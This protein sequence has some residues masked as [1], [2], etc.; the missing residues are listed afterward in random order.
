MVAFKLAELYPDLVHA[1]VISGSIL[2][3]TDSIS[4]TN[5]QRLG[6]SSSSEL[7]LPSSVKGLKTLLRVACHKKLWFPDCLYK[8]YLEVIFTNRKERSEL[9]EALVISNKDVSVPTFPQ[10]IHL[11]WGENDQIF[12]LELAQTMKEQLV[13][14]ATIQGIKKA[15]HLVH[16]ERPCVYNR[17]LKQFL[18]SLYE[19]GSAK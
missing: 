16:L 14:N 17:C 7:L 2:N 8:D 4:E 11:L 3:M 9:L 19:D 12:R 15:G 1:L 18:A 5:L 10:K 6:F 13:S